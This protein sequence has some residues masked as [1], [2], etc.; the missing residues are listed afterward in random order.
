MRLS[1]LQKGKQHN[2]TNFNQV[3][4]SKL[5]TFWW[6]SIVTITHKS[7]KLEMN[8]KKILYVKPLHVPNQIT[9]MKNNAELRNTCQGE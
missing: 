2:S 5:Q 9:I 6:S 8:V 1:G 4:K 3:N 7:S